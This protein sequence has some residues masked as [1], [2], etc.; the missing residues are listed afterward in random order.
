MKNIELTGSEKDFLKNS[1]DT[2]SLFCKG[3]GNCV[4]Q[5][6]KGLPVEGLW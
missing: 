1:R 2:A 3:C 4:H 6:K 5:C